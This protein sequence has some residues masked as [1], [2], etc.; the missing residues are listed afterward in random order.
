M[1]N[2]REEKRSRSAILALS[3]ENAACEE[4]V[5]EFGYLFLIR[6]QA[7]WEGY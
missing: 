5:V 2:G 1:S 3:H 6:D 4:L 7:H